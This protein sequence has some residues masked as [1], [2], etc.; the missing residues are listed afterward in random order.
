MKRILPAVVLAAGFSRRM[1]R[2]KLTLTLDGE[3]LV[4]RAVR[5]ALEAG[6]APVF[7]TMR[8]DASPELR[9]AVSGFDERV[10][11]VPAPDARLGQSESLKAGI[12]RLLSRF[13]PGSDPESSAFQEKRPEGNRFPASGRG[14]SEPERPEPYG[15][16]CGG[17]GS[18][19][20]AAPGTDAPL[21]ASAVPAVPGAMI[22]LGDQP[23]V[24]A[25]L[26]RALADFFLEE[27]ER[28]AAPACG[29][30]R[31]NPVVLPAGAF[32]AVLRLDGDTGARSILAAF[33]LRLLP[34]ND[35][36][37]LTDVDTWEAYES[38]SRAKTS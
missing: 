4:R 6:L 25:E 8:P 13:S 33:G 23:L 16:A 17:P 19:P 2:C 28:A 20:E 37:A 11:I 18:S 26:V 10:E 27:P 1:G 21:P 31:G 3:P 30:V 5:A 12:R 14:R 34:T 38:L 15:Q 22:L 24:G 35:T 9:A 36:A 32:A 7:V 29:G